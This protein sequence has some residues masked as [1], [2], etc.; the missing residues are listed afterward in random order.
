MRLLSLSVPALPSPHLLLLT[1]V[2]WRQSYA[3]SLSHLPTSIIR[4]IEL[5]ASSLPLPTLHRHPLQ[6]IAIR[7]YFT[8]SH[9]NIH[10][11]CL[12]TQPT[13]QQ[14]GHT[15]SWCVLISHHLTT[16]KINTNNPAR[17]PPQRHRALQYQARLR[18]QSI[19]PPQT[20]RSPR[21]ILTNQQNAPTPAGLNA[22]S[23]AQR[24][25][26]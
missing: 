8:S 2:R 14:A 26:S 9:I 24:M 1:A 18:R 7:H 4:S 5:S 19:P 25:G 16:R 12:P 21:N 3:P 15:A 22:S 10:T 6:Q 20:P 11:P 17:L 23:C 13:S